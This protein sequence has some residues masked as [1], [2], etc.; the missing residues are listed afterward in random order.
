MEFSVLRISLKTNS[1]ELKYEKA[2]LGLLFIESN[3]NL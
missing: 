1:L 2:I 3:P